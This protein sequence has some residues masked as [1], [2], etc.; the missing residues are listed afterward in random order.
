[1]SACSSDPLGIKLQDRG[2]YV[3]VVSEQLGD[4]LD[5]ATFGPRFCTE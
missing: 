1:M 5:D 3:V 4:A 2:D